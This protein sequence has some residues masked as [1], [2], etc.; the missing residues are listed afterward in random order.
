MKSNSCEVRVLI[1]GRPATEFFHE[2][3]NFMEGRGGSEFEIEVRNVTAKR[4][5]A[6]VSVD[7]LSVI[8]GQVAGLESPGY[9]LNPFQ[10]IVIPGWKLDDNRAAKF[11][12]GSRASSYVQSVQG[13]ATN[14][15]VI[16]V[17]VWGE[18]PPVNHVQTCVMRS[19]IPKGM[20]GSLGGGMFAA[21]ASA[22]SMDMSM[23]S[24]PV[25]AAASVN[26]LGT[27]FG[28]ATTFNTSSVTF[29]KDAVVD[30][31]VMYYDDARGL[32]ARGIVIE[33]PVQRYTT[34]P[35]PFPGIGCTPPPG[36]KG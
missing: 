36:W 20:S 11:E 6:V 34:T 21:S 29:E 27:G 31:L 35:N 1:K 4:L 7:G 16:G 14:C 9:I 10:T 25:A 33:R 5:M 22:A 8:S 24:T 12:F 30:T 13:E 23:E 15:G 17:M 28:A 2:G 26:N 32:K 19:A 18:K 3:Q